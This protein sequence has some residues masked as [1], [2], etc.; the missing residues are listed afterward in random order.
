[1]AYGRPVLSVLTPPTHDLRRTQL[2][3]LWLAP[4]KPRAGCLGIVPTSYLLTVQFPLV[5]ETLLLL[6]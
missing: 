5:D 4:G 3:P 2:L 1:M 6:T